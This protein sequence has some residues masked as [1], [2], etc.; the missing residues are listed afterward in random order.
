[1][2]VRW[3]FNV[4]ARIDLETI[5][6]VRRDDDGVDDELFYSFAQVHELVDRSQRVAVQN[7]DSGEYLDLAIGYSTVQ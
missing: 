1:L 2:W 5:V 3:L 7:R 6:C 4:V